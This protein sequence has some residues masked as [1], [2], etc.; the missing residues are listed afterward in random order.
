MRLFAAALLALAAGSAAAAPPLEDFDGQPHR[1]EEFTSDSRWLV[2]MIWASDCHVCNAEAS[3]YVE[4]HER[5]KGR[6]ASVLGIAIDGDAGRDAARQFVARNRVTFPNLLG[7]AEDVQRWYEEET[8][9]PFFGTPTFLVIAPGGAIAAKQAG[10]VPVQLIENFI[11]ANATS[12]PAP[13]E[14]R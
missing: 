2:V 11:T 4:F 1:L 7:E 13:G 8:G 14:Q 5:H 12:E 10:A 3:H 9:E 6:D